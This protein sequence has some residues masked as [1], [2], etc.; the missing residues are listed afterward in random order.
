MKGYFEYFCDLKRGCMKKSVFIGLLWLA[1]M[2]STSLVTAVAGTPQVQV[3]VVLNP[4][5]GDAIVLVPGGDPPSS[6]LNVPLRVEFNASLV[7]DDGKE[8]IMF[9]QWTVERMDEDKA[10]YVSYLK[11][12]ESVTE[13]EFTDEG[14][15]KVKFDWSYREK[16]SVNAVPVQVASSDSVTFTIDGSE[17]RLYNAFSPNGDGINDV[18]KIYARSIVSMKIAIFNRWGQTIKTVSGKI[19]EVLPDDAE[20]ESD[21]GFLFEVWDGKHNGDIV[22]DGVYFINVQAVGAGGKVY[23]KRADINVL[24]GLGT[25]H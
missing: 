12:Q 22:N 2:L 19:D 17:I 16:D 6:N 20:P 24:K 25:G 5:Q 4:V 11:R 9:P 8:Y 15:Y 23:E 18:Y 13:Y 1:G 7:A 21:G 10:V 3:K 14:N